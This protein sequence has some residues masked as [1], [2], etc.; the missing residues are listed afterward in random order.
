M[1]EI[2]REK[3]RFYIGDSSQEPDAEILFEEGEPGVYAVT[4]TFVSPALRGSGAARAL[5]DKVVDL[6]RAERKRIRPVCSY[7][8]KVMTDAE[9]YQDV[10]VRQEQ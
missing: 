1:P 3:N 6:A 4:R 9:A 10:L 8:V 5:L 7:A 2:H